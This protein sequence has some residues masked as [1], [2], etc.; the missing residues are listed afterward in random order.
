MAETKSFQPIDRF[1]G[2][3]GLPVQT[4]LAAQRQSRTPCSVTSFEFGPCGAIIAGRLRPFQVPT[5]VRSSMSSHSISA[6]AF[7]DKSREMIRSAEACAGGFC[8][9]DFGRIVSNN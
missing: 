7:P 1:H 3:L 4:S 9:P 6:P 5:I 8:V 2:S